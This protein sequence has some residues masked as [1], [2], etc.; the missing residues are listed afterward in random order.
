MQPRGRPRPAPFGFF[1]L[2]DAGG[3]RLRPDGRC[4][5][6]EVGG[7]RPRDFILVTQS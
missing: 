5:R 7:S 1:D 3:D 4:G 6:L 2:C